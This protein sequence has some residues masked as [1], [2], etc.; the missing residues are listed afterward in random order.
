MINFQLGCGDNQV[1]IT[2]TCKDVD[3]IANISL[4]LWM[5]SKD[6]YATNKHKLAIKIKNSST[7]Y[8]IVQLLYSSYLKLPNKN[9]FNGL[10]LPNETQSK[11]YVGN[12]L[13]F[14]IGAPLIWLAKLAPNGDFIYS[15]EY[16]DR[17]KRSTPDELLFN[18]LANAY[19]SGYGTKYKHV[20]SKNNL[21]DD[22][23]LFTHQGLGPV[24]YYKKMLGFELLQQIS[25]WALDNKKHVVIRMHPTADEIYTDK[26][27]SLK[28]KYITFDVDSY[29][30]DLVSNCSQLWT[31]S[32]AC[33][34]EAMLMKKPVSIFGVPDYHPAVNNADSI[35]QAYKTTFDYEKYVRF[36]TWYARNLCINI[37][38]AKAPDKMYKRMYDYFIEGKPIA[39]LY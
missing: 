9:N 34:M 1:V 22:Y 16:A 26:L 28:N 37:H 6:T 23:I 10:I 39:D 27:Y 15:Y 36:M 25:S 13:E 33:G 17:Y 3:K 29:I 8:K 11:T 32:S 35:E 14:R 18:S 24:H 30:V 12:G 5:E 2:D 21:P 7:Q 4:K 20:H 38:N 19:I 31:V